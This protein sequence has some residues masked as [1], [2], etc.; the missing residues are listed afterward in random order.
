[1]RRF[2][3]RVYFFAYFLTHIFLGTLLLRQAGFWKTALPLSFIDAFFLSVSAVC[4]TGLSPVDVSL[5]T[6][7]GRWI[8]LYLIEAGALGILLF[9]VFYLL[10]P[11]GRISFSDSRMIREYYIEEETDTKERSLLKTVFSVTLLSQ[12][13]GGL[14]LGLAFQKAGTDTPFFT[15]LFHAISAFANAGFSL[16]PDSLEQFNNRPFILLILMFLIILGGTGFLVIHDLILRFRRGRKGSLSLHTKITL[17]CIPVLVL[18][19]M[20]LF[21]ASEWNGAFRHLSFKEKFWAG[22]FQSVTTRT[23]GFNTVPQEHLSGFSSLL[24][25]IFMFIGGGSGSTAGGLKMSTFF[26]LAVVLLRGLRVRKDILIFRRRISRAQLITASVIFFKALTFV[27]F[28]TLS[29]LAVEQFAGHIV[30]PFDALFEV[31]SAMGTVGLS[32]ELTPDRLSFGGKFILAAAMIT[33][34]L[35][36]FTLITSTFRSSRDLPVDYPGEEVLIG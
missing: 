8:L 33:G 1:M 6:G 19:G 18:T 7:G 34:R 25:L 2:S 5:L 35:G 15:G 24:T 21:T 20:I 11:K 22:L 28:F 17:L 36:L 10:N 32:G 29:L 12:I 9:A 4:V 3:G 23:A 31:I 16:F 13:S 27:L 26:I 14:L 30:P